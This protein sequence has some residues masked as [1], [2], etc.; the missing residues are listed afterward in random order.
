MYR[1]IPQL[2]LN[3]SVL[4]P[5]AFLEYHASVQF[6]LLKVISWREHFNRAQEALAWAEWARM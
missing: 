5:K 4:R 1:S 3:V 6:G 2:P